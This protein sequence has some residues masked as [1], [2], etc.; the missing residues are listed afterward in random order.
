MWINDA[1][2]GVIWSKLEKRSHSELFFFLVGDQYCLDMVS[3]RL[4]IDKGRHSQQW[5]WDSCN[6]G[7]ACVGAVFML[8]VITENFR[9]TG[10]NTMYSSII[11]LNHWVIIPL[12]H[13]VI[14]ED[15]VCQR[16]TL[17]SPQRF[18]ILEVLGDAL[19][20]FIACWWLHRAWERPWSLTPL[21][22]LTHKT[23]DSNSTR[24]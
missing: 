1:E 2:L 21:W 5:G 20:D 11:P 3:L 24:I 7:P 14:L 9:F 15:R 22:S 10:A 19:W 16:M 13:W 6:P 12:N 8:P 18:W 4:C 17:F 23:R